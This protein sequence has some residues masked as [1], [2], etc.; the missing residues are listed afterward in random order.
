MSKAKY[1]IRNGQDVVGLLWEN[2][3]LGK[4]LVTYPDI[5]IDMNFDLEIWDIETHEVIDYIDLRDFLLESLP[6]EFINV[7]NPKKV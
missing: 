2:E 5:K 6:M 3:K 7:D 1:A 4:V